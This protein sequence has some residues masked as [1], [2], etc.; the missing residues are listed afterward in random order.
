MGSPMSKGSE[1]ATTSCR[2]RS[3]ASEEVP[4]ESAKS[5]RISSSAVSTG[6]RNTIRFSMTARCCNGRSHDSRRPQPDLGPRRGRR[7]LCLD[8]HDHWPAI[9][10]TSTTAGDRSHR[11]HAQTSAC[12]STSARRSDAASRS[13]TRSVRSVAASD[14]C[15]RRCPARSTATAP[16]GL[17][18][19][20]RRGSGGYSSEASEGVQA[21]GQPGAARCGR[22]QAGRV[23]VTRTD[24]GL[25][26]SRVLRR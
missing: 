11:S 2:H 5:Q 3:R 1:E 23:L 25:A 13:T 16:P 7:V 15:R 24:S 22:G 6:E 4:G 9:M 20:H 26:E 19:S 10:S 18:S 17:P 14:V 12:R 21:G 8:R